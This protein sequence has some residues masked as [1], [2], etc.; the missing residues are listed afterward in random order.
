MPD[1]ARLK[2]M[3]FALSH[4]GTHNSLLTRSLAL[5]MAAEEVRGSK[6]FCKLLGVILRVGNYINHGVA[7]T[8]GKI[9][10][11]AIESLKSLA[12]FKTGSVSTMHFL[13]VTMRSR[14]LNFNR[15]LQESL[16]HTQEASREKVS[17]LKAGI[18]LFNQQTQ[19]ARYEMEHLAYDDVAREQMTVLT[20]TL[21]C[22][23]KEL[24]KQL[25]T[26]VD[27]AVKAQKYFS[28]SQRAQGN[29]LPIEQFFGHIAEFL[30]DFDFTW[31]E[32]EKH[33]ARWDLYFD[34][35]RKIPRALSPAS[36]STSTG[37]ATAPSEWSSDAHTEEFPNIWPSQ[38]PDRKE[39]T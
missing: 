35:A 14:D 33:S 3:K 1:S 8:E 36:F 11:F 4:A 5:H 17:L 2:L 38:I 10:G 28:V 19:L 37:S 34:H 6:E 13:C 30:N 20:S 29:L 39:V 16:K 32:V 22:E 25:D 15:N 24:M 26:A 12:I 9:R 18:E 31:M 7:E 27:L 23:A 21:E